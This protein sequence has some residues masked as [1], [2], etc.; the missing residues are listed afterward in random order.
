MNLSLL[1][2]SLTIE[3]QDHSSSGSQTSHDLEDKYWVTLVRIEQNNNYKG[4]SS[5][6]PS[7]EQLIE[8]AG[9]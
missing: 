3:L 1:R 2:S 7:T 9:A 6:I 5:N 4:V 8:S